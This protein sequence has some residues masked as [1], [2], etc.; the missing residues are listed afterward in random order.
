MQQRNAKIRKDRAFQRLRPLLGCLQRFN[1]AFFNGRTDNKGLMS[2]LCLLA[3]KA[4]QT[5]TV[6]L[7]HQKGFH[8]LPSGRQLVNDGNIQIAVKNQCKRPRNGCC[9]HNQQMRPFSLGKQ[10]GSL[11]HP[12]T[13]LFIRDDKTE[14]GKHGRL[15]QQS[16][17]A[18][19]KRIFAVCNFLADVFFLRRRHGAGQKDAGNLPCGKHRSKSVKMLPCQNFRRGH[20]RRLPS[21]FC[22]AV[23]GCRRN[24]RFAAADIA[25]HQTAH[26][27]S[28]AEVGENVVDCPRLS[29]CQGKRQTAVKIRHVAC[30]HRNGRKHGAFCANRCQSRRKNIKFFKDQT[31][32]RRL[33]C[34]GTGGQMN[35]AQ[36]G[37]RVTQVVGLQHVF[38]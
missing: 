12:E 9:G 13:V 5:G 27:F 33:Q 19:H 28:A 34:L 35:F 36:S 1:L 21:V 32:P 31:L 22:R 10:S 7:I 15:R 26:R 3:D 4:V 29:V 30:L 16:V 6:A 8:R 17:R 23:G 24:H 38:G 37:C 18:N 20:E 14:I 25:L 2:L 11:R